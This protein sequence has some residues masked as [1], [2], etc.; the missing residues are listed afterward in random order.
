[1]TITLTIV[2]ILIYGFVTGKIILSADMVG[3]LVGAIATVGF[4]AIIR[5]IFGK[6]ST[7]GTVPNGNS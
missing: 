3:L 4:V 7:N 5:A 2:G 1:M 6:A